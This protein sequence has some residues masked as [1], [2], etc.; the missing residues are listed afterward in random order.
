MTMPDERTRAVLQTRDFL[1]SLMS[2]VET[3]GVPDSVR[4]AARRLLRHFPSAWELTL[5][6]HHLP[7][8]FGP[9]APRHPAD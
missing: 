8:W 3:P 6:H 4:T 5:V 9:A 1:Q 2:S 7:A